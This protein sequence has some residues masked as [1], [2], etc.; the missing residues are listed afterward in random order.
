MVSCIRLTM[1]PYPVRNIRLKAMMPRIS[2][3]PK[4][5]IRKK[6]LAISGMITRITATI[7]AAGLSNSARRP[8]TGRRAALAGGLAWRRA[9]GASCVSDMS[10]PR[11]QALRPQRQHDHHDQERHHDGV[12]R[13]VDRA[14]LLGETDDQR[15]QRCP[16][17]RPHATDDHDDEGCQQETG[18]L[19]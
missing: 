12:G 14:E 11:E 17:D 9:P 5:S 6:P 7:Q 8:A 3:V 15:A 2:V 16:R 1:P 18:I 4:I 10:S 13:D 19:A